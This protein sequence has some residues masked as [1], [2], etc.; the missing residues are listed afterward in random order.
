MIVMKK[1]LVLAALFCCAGF[2]FAQKQITLD[3]CFVFYKFYP[4]SGARYK[5][6]KDGLHYI[7]SEEGKLHIRSVLNEKFD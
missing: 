5:Y 6:M 4:E 3:D 2:L 1:T 7:D